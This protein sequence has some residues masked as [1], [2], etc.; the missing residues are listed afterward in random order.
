M[1]KI[2]LKHVVR[3][4][5]RHGNDRFYFRVKDLAKV[6]LPG[7]PGLEEFMESYQE[8]LRRQTVRAGGL[9]RVSEGSFA[10][11]C[12]TYFNS[13]TFKVELAPLTRNTRRR[14]LINLH[15]A[16]GDKPFAKIE[17]R[18]VRVWLDDRADRPEAANGLLKA[19]RALFKFAVDRGIAKHNPVAEISKIKAKTDGHHT[20]TIS[21]VHQFEERHALGSVAR[22]AMALL[23]YTGSRRG[24]VVLLGR[25]HIRDGWIE[26][27]HGK[28]RAEVDLPI[29]PQLQA[30]LDAT[31][32][33]QMTFLV[34]SFGKPF[35][36]NG[37][38]N[39]MRQWCDQAGLSHCSCHG[40]RK[41]GA[42][43]AAENGASDLQLMA[44]FGWTRAEMATLYTRRANRRKLSQDAM[45][46]MVPRT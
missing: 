3:D 34:S 16:I 38:G 40:L 32:L 18:H 15:P 29:L 27:R 5:D 8:A 20:W 45:P 35:T 21:E 28:T 31:H 11:L 46:L 6:R 2:D 14:I 17:A 30:V 24:D 10:W 44:I 42:T 9:Q 33:G 13:T 19:L 26:F 36:A 37:F 23:L 41:A 43:I 39:V 1:V 12:H 4:I 22:L 25:Q 7:I